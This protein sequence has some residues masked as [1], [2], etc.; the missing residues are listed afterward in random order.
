MHY[1]IISVLSSKHFKESKRLWTE[2]FIR[3]DSTLK[4]FVPLKYERLKIPPYPNPSFKEWPW[5]IILYYS[6][7]FVALKYVFPKKPDLS[8]LFSPGGTPHA[9]SQVLALSD[10]AIK[11]FYHF[12]PFSSIH[13]V[14]VGIFDFKAVRFRM[15]APH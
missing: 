12:V 14:G 7:L 1:L 3:A 4:L 6:L 15:F 5:I 2:I 8:K 11:M 9:N 13:T 10:H